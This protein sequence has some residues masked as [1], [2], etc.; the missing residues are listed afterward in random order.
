MLIVEFVDENEVDKRRSFRDDDFDYA[1]LITIS[2]SY[3]QA[4]LFES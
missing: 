3:I 4:L 1:V 2:K